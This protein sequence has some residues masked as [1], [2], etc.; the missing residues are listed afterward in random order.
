MKNSRKLSIVVVLALAFTLPAF[1]GEISTTVAEE[2]PPPAPTS[3]TVKEVITTG[4]GQTIGGSSL[5]E[6][7][8][9]LLQS[10]LALF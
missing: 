3:A 4:S 6:A 2:P 1:A 9:N 5:T 7:A 10:A 8:L